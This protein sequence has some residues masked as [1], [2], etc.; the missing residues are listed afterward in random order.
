MQHSVKRLTNLSQIRASLAELRLW[1][2]EMIINY[3]DGV[4]VLKARE[5][6]QA[7]LAATRQNMEHLLEGQ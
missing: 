6:W 4:A 2:K 3:E 5:R 1:E 7:A